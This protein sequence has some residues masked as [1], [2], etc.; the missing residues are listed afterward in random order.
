MK[1]NPYGIMAQAFVEFVEANGRQRGVDLL[2][3]YGV[4]NLMDLPTRKWPGF[5]GS[6]HRRKMYTLVR[7]RIELE[8][9]AKKY[10]DPRAGACRYDA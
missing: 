2:A 1:L 6:L 8:R 3:R 4:S 5:Y 10:A 9:N 7:E